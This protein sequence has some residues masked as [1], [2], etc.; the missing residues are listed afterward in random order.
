[1]PTDVSEESFTSIFSA[2]DEISREWNRYGEAETEA[3]AASEPIGKVLSTRKGKGKSKVYL[4]TGHEG[5]E[6]E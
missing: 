3:E 5:P 2:E 6:V 1:M 4:I